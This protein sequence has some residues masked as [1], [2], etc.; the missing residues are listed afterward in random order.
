MLS[1]FFVGFLI[2]NFRHLLPFVQMTDPLDGYD[3]MGRLP[4][5]LANISNFNREFVKVH[6]KDYLLF[7]II[8]LG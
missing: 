2:Y 5:N 6:F 8:M 7:W 1:C 3:L 4:E